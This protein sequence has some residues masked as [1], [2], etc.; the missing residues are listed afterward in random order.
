MN[1]VLR[2]RPSLLLLAVLLF[3]LGRTLVRL[4]VGE[5]T[6]ALWLTAAASGAVAVVVLLLIL[7]A[8]HRPSE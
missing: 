1:D 8:S 3:A 5:R 4:V 2:S 7:R 6:R